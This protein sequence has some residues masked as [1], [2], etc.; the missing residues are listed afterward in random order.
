M[1]ILMVCLGNIC[2]SPLAEGILQAK[3]AAAGL[4]WQIDS[5]GTNGYH[6]G[7]SPHPLS[8]KVA[9]ING[10]DISQQRARRFRAADFEE[11]DLIYAMAED[12]I[13]EMKSIARQRFDAAKVDLLMNV[14][15]P[16][17]NLD[18]PDPWYGTEPGYH[19]V[20]AMISQACDKLIENHQ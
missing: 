6:V 14:L 15:H 8:Q 17:K 2:R 10:I 5:A 19:E 13:D 18:V 16:G 11:F 9:K 12:V 1:K 20:Y 7:E 4:N 3:A